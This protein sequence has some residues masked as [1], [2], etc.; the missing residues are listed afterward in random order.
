MIVVVAMVV[1]INSVIGG[2]GGK[3]SVWL[4]ASTIRS[5]VSDYRQLS[6]YNCTE[7]FVKNNYWS[8]VNLLK[9]YSIT[10]DIAFDLTSIIEFLP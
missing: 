2:F 4:D 3:D 9:K 7:W 6:G 8:P 10:R 1:V 5:Q